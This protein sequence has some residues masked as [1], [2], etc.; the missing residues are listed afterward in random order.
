MYALVAD[1]AGSTNIVSVDLD[2]QGAFVSVVSD[3]PGNQAVAI[4]PNGTTA[5]VLSAATNNV[6]V[7]TIG[8][9]GTLQDTHQRVVLAGG[10][11]GPRT[12][13]IHP[14]GTLALVTDQLQGLVSVLR[15]AN[16]V[17][18]LDGFIDNL[19]LNSSGVV[20]TPDGDTAY[21]SN[22]GSSNVAVLDITTDQDG[23]VSVADTEI[24][25]FIPNGTPTAFFGVPG[26]GVTPDGLRLFVASSTSTGVSVV[27]TTTNTVSPT[28]IV[29][30]AAVRGIGMPGP[31]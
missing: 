15:S 1:G 30:A 17:W 22:F 11:N 21:V 5:L 20:M 14:S 26:M 10:I 4:T 16:D 19:G 29:T 13:A 8:P 25:I 18:T 27:D 23:I 31:R 6:A 24:R 2:H 12:V 3:L 28:T 9:D 7:L